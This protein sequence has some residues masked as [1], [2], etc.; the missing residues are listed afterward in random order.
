MTPKDVH[1]DRSGW[2]VLALKTSEPPAPNTKRRRKPYM[3]QSC[4]RPFVSEQQFWCS[5]KFN[6]IDE[7]HNHYSRCIAHAELLVM[8]RLS[9]CACRVRLTTVR[10]EEP[11]GKRGEAEEASG[12]FISAAWL[13]LRFADMADWAAVKSSLVF[14]WFHRACRGP[15]AEVTSGGLRPVDVVVT[16][17]KS[18]KA[19]EEDRH[20]EQLIEISTQYHRPTSILSTV[21]NSL[22]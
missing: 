8:R 18:R 17:H 5:R 19:L 21:M 9:G 13:S 16:E 22:R 11:E 3:S 20:L 10:R 12:R 1:W 15:W 2:R 14:V 4:S 7:R 6:I